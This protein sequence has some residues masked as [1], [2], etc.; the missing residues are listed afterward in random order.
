[1]CDNASNNDTIIVKLSKLLPDF[2]G[3]A[4]WSQCFTHVLNLVVKSILHQFDV[5]KA[6][7]NEAMDEAAKELAELAAGLE[8]KELLSQ[9]S[10]TAEGSEADDNVD[11]WIDEHDQMTEDEINNLMEDVKSVRV[12]L[13]KVCNTTE[14]SFLVT[15]SFW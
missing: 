1:M 5:P 3:A 11:G 12:M 13:V 9:A 7:E 4:N 14:P 10:A 6:Q 15:D 8:L 2:P